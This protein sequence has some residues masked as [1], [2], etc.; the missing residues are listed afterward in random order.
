MPD[1][2]YPCHCCGFWTLSD[3]QSGSYEICPVCFWE[4]DPVQNE[5]PG[6]AG[7]ANQLCLLDARLNFVRF[8]AFDERAVGH[9]R[10]PLPKEFPPYFV[11]HGLGDEEAA[12]RQRAL[13]MQ[14]LAI[15]RSMRTG[16][17]G[18][19][20][21]STRIAPLV[22]QVEDPVLEKA[23]LAFVGVASEVD[24]L[25]IGRERELWNQDA[26]AVKDRQLGEYQ[27]RIKDQM[28]ADCATVER[29]LIADLTGA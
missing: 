16:S 3:P 27:S 26:L 17:E 13:R 24:D 25:P 22:H 10:P 14:I 6:Y 8:G 20:I 7:G 15:V 11:P 12:M 9:V 19:I 1:R 2:L 21:G 28:L 29:L 5:D 18:V 4:D 23:M